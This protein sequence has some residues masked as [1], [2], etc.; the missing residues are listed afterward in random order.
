M[1]RKYTP[2]QNRMRERSWMNEKAPK[3]KVKYIPSHQREG[4]DEKKVIKL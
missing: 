2:Q 3:V 4:F 1:K